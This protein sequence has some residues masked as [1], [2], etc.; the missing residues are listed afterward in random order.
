VFQEM[1]SC[2]QNGPE[3]FDWDDTTKKIADRKETAQERFART[4]AA[5][6]VEVSS[7]S[8]EMLI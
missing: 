7:L 4:L 8:V 1:L 6:G 5:F 2:V 3:E